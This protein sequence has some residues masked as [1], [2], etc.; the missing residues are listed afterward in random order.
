MAVRKDEAFEEL[1]LEG[2]GGLLQTFRRRRLD[3]PGQALANKGQVDHGGGGVKADAVAIRHDQRLL[4]LAAERADFAQAPAQGAARIVR[5]VPQELAESLAPVRPAG[6]RQVGQQGPGL[7]RRR[8]D[9]ALGAAGDLHLAEEPDLQH[10]RTA[11]FRR[12]RH[13]LSTAPPR[14]AA[15]RGLRCPPPRASE[16]PARRPPPPAYPAAVASRFHARGC[17][18]RRRLFP[19]RLVAGGAVEFASPVEF[20]GGDHRGSN[21]PGS[22]SVASGRGVATQRRKEPEM[23]S[24]MTTSALSPVHGGYWRTEHERVYRLQALRPPPAS[25]RPPGVPRANACSRAVGTRHG[26]DRRLVVAGAQPPRA[27]GDVRRH[28]QGHRPQPRRRLARGARAVLAALTGSP[29]CRAAHR[30]PPSR[31]N[32][33]LGEAGRAEQ[34]RRTP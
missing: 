14:V 13:A 10:A 23:T 12:R 16:C 26:G 15:A 27:A 19:G 31:V 9:Q 17:D 1:A 25:G 6:D 11:I 24:A 4:G 33:R 28:A 20:H 2:G 7:L 8:Q 22:S 18:A 30:P 21:G 32:V 29:D 3:P 5:H 34:P